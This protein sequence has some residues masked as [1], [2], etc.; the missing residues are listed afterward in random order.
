MGVWSDVE[1]VLF[2][3]VRGTHVVRE[4]P[5]ADRPV[6]PLRKCATYVDGADSCDVALTHFELRLEWI[7]F[8][9]VGTIPSFGYCSMVRLD[10]SF[11][12]EDIQRSPR[13]TKQESPLRREPEGGFLTYSVCSNSPTLGRCRVL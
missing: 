2:G 8:I 11:R 12:K 5:R 1:A 4:A 6:S 7:A 13:A 10:P 3:H 9:H